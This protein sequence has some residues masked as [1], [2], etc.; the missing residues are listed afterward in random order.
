MNESEP[1][2]QPVKIEGQVSLS[3]VLKR[4][5][6]AQDAARFYA[7]NPGL[8]DSKETPIAFDTKSLPPSSASANQITRPKKQPVRVA[9][10]AGVQKRTGQV[11][12]G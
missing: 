9:A 7:Y 2:V 4:Q 12:T 11:F 10:A 8:G 6:L 3:D 5:R 1:L